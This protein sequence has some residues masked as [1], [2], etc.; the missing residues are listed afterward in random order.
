MPGLRLTPAQAVGSGASRVT[1]ARR[2]SGPSLTP[3]S[4]WKPGTERSSA[5]RVRAS[6]NRR[7]TES[8]GR[9][10]TP[11]GAGR[12]TSRLVSQFRRLVIRSPGRSA[13]AAM[14]V[15]GWGLIAF[16]LR[17]H[18]FIRWGSAPNPG[19]V[20]CGDPSAPRRSLARRAPAPSLGAPP[21][22]RLG[23]LRGPPP[24]RAAPAHAALR[25]PTSGALPQ[26]PARSLA[27]P[28]P[29]DR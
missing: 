29:G 1:F 21:Q 4:W 18:L 27:A 8:A 16:S 19:S 11:T 17:H 24:P 14:F 22:P 15:E 9:L 23:R 28:A 3:D 25:A 6:T 5:P 13:S 20:A 7:R 12:L 2:C 10:G 26:T